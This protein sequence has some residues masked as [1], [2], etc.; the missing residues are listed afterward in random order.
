MKL[1]QIYFCVCCF[2]FPAFRSS[3]QESKNNLQLQVGVTSI[4]RQDLIFSP[5]IHR[6]LSPVNI[7]IRYQRDSQWYQNVGLRMAIMNPVHMDLFNFT[8]NGQAASTSS[9]AF[10]FIDAE[11]WIGKT[12][13]T[14]NGRSYKVGLSVNADIQALNYMYGRIG[15]F[16]YYAAFGIGGFAQTT[17][18]LNDNNRITAFCSLPIGTWLARSP[19]LI[20]DDEFIENTASHNSLKTFFSFIGDGKLTTLHK[21]QTIDLGVNY[22][23][24][25]NSKLD[26]GMGYM[27]EFIHAN[28]PRS[29]LSYRNSLTLNASFKF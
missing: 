5:F 7:G 20:N 18:N 21:L 16:G 23:Y 26:V 28:E 17:Y 25:I 8:D 15:S 29:L 24:T 10:T 9:H 12:L 6:D 14:K 19:Y 11:Y 13:E 2:L 22:T 4:A 1:F 27:F 3:A